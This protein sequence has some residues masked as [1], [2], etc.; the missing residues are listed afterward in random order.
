MPAGRSETGSGIPDICFA[1]G[2]C[3]PAGV[4]VRQ[5]YPTRQDAF[6][7]EWRHFHHAVTARRPPKTSIAD[8]RTDL[9]LFARMMA[10][11]R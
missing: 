8:A 2:I 11:M 5:S 6:V 1:S 7:P 3:A 9:E 10:V 4:S